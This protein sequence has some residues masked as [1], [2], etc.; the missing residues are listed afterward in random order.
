MKKFSKFQI[1][2]LAMDSVNGLFAVLR[3]S[4]RCLCLQ[5]KPSDTITSPHNTVLLCK[6]NKTGRKNIITCTLR[7]QQSVNISYN[8]NYSLVSPDEKT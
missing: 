7:M 2:T 5:R 6:S 3:R 4:H 1:L 8:F